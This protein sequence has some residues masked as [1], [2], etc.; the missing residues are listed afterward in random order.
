[1]TKSQLFRMNKHGGHPA[2]PPP[3]PIHILQN[4]VGTAVTSV[5]IDD[6]KLIS[7]DDHGS[8]TIWNLNVMIK[9]MHIFM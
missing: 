8:I 3:D 7:G 9:K 2:P 6:Q 4:P 5:T 1:M